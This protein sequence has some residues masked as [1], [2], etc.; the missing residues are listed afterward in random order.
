MS[1]QTAGEAPL[2]ADAPPSP[3]ADAPPVA[4]TPPTADAPPAAGP[5]SA[6]PPD[7]VSHWDFARV[8]AILAA[9]PHGRWVSY[10][11]V[12]RAAGGMDSH[13]RA[14]NQRLIRT[15]LPGSHR[16]LKSDGSVATTALGAPDEVRRRLEAEGIEFSNG[17]APQAARHRPAPYEPPPEGV[18]AG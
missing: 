11:D 8:P 1:I 3:A 4:D 10:G 14:L 18:G 16:V 12:A 15:R 7:A 9:V 5:G 2:A 13:A 17:R 6:E